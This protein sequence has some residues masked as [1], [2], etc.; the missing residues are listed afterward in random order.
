MTIESTIDALAAKGVLSVLTQFSDI[1]GV[2]KG[3]LVP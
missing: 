2:T 3:K 1:H